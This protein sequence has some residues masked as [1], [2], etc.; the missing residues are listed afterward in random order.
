MK[1]MDNI[2]LLEIPV[3]EVC[4]LRLIF[5]KICILLNINPFSSLLKWKIRVFSNRLARETVFRATYMFISF[6]CGIAN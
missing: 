2:F 4:A 5:D 1:V 6:S 3:L